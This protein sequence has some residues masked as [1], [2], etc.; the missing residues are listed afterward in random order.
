M[1]TYGILKRFVTFIRCH[2]V[3]LFYENSTLKVSLVLPPSL[4]S[5]RRKN[6]ECSLRTEML[7]R[8]SNV[9]LPSTAPD[10]AAHP[11]CRGNTS[12]NGV[13]SL[14]HPND[15]T[16]V[17][18][19]V[20]TYACFGLDSAHMQERMGQQRCGGEC[21]LVGQAMGPCSRGMLWAL[22]A[23][24]SRWERFCDPLLGPRK[25]GHQNFLLMW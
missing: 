23:R 20:E 11:G 9:F 22:S 2:P 3:Y 15:A 5:G 16:F 4:T 18:F 12:E 19:C 24:A 6:P 13:L 14:S 21:N 17:F 10:N 25:V 1:H 8:P 7:N